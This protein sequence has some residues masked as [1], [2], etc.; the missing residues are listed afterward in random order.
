MTETDVACIIL[1]IVNTKLSGCRI[2]FGRTHKIPQRFMG[3][4][5]AVRWDGP[6]KRRGG[7]FVLIC[8]YKHLRNQEHRVVLK[9]MLQDYSEQMKYLKEN[10]AKPPQKRRKPFQPVQN[11]SINTTNDLELEVDGEWV[12]YGTYLPTNVRELQPVEVQ[13]WLSVH[14]NPS[15]TTYNQSI[16]GDI[17][18]SLPDD[19]HV[20][21]SIQDNRMNQTNVALGSDDNI[22]FNTNNPDYFTSQEH[23]YNSECITPVVP[24]NS[25]DDYY[26]RDVVNRQLSAVIAQLVNIGMG[27][28]VMNSVLTNA[29]LQV[30]RSGQTWY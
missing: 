19:I 27:P 11:S 3:Y 30:E 2:R 8:D 26:V 6:T 15:T 16:S 14:N 23:D 25:F 29:K 28:Y 17:T 21:S 1:Q 5:R 22:G 13:N 10:N 12:S 20:V 4:I 7:A 9:Q 24:T 18:D